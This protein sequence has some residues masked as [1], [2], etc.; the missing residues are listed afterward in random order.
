MYTYIGPVDY[1]TEDDGPTEDADE[2]QL[3]EDD[4]GDDDDEQVAE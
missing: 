1:N 3:P 2:I 4:D